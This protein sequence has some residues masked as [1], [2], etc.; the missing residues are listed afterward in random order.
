MFYILSSVFVAFLFIFRLSYGFNFFLLCYTLRFNKKYAILNKITRNF[1]MALELIPASFCLTEL[2]KK[3]MLATLDT[4]NEWFFADGAFN[5]A[6]SFD[7]PGACNTWLYERYA[8][9]YNKEI[10]AYFDG[11]W[12][13]PVDIIASFRAINFNPKYGRLFVVS[14][15]KYLDYLFVNRGCM[16]FNWSVAL[17]NQ[18]ALQQYERFIKNY[19]GRKIGMRTHAQKVILEK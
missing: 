6:T 13:R 1:D 5:T 18:H 16:A 15:L 7:Q 19:C 12:S 11:M 3:I 8:V 2:T 9:L 10:I 14:I 4:R 17:Q